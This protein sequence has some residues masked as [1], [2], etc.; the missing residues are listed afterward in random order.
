M[1]Q[2]A[3][4]NFRKI[5][6]SSLENRALETALHG[7]NAWLRMMASQF[8]T[9]AGEVLKEDRLTCASILFAAGHKDAAEMLRGF[10]FNTNTERK[11]A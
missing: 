1:T 4:R 2:K 11:A 6:G 10:D 5:T 7:K 9:W 8:R 3:R